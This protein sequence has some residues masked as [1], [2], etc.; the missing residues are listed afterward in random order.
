MSTKRFI[1]ANKFFLQRKLK[2]YTFQ[3]QK[4]KNKKSINLRS[5]AIV[6]G[7]NHKKCVVDPFYVSNGAANNRIIYR[8]RKKERKLHYKS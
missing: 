2:Y 7:I 3:K 8:E 4:N 5:Y 1:N 6:A